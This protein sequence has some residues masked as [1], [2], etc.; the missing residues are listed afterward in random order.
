MTSNTSRKSAKLAL[1]VLLFAS[2]FALAQQYPLID[3]LAGKVIDKVNA[4]T[5]EQLW[6]G[7]GKPKSAREQ[8]LVQLLRNDPGAR[9]EFINRIAG[10]VANK[11]FECG[12][13]P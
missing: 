5:C 13:I 4:S 3:L 9:K 11:M 2:G 7:R 1:P 10:P 6:E 12:M 8:E